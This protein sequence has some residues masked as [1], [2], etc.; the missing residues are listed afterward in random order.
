MGGVQLQRIAYGSDESHFG[1]L[2]RASGTSHAGTVVIVHGGF[3]RAQYGL[4]LGAP[5][6]T[7]LAARGY[8]CWNI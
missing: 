3:W 6:A 4:S 5:L 8:N 7:D 1:D 2:Y